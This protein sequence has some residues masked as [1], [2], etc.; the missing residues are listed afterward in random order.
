MCNPVR[1]PVQQRS[2]QAFAAQHFR[3]LR[4]GQIGG[5]QQAGAFIR[6][7]HHLEEQP[8][9]GLGE[10]DIAQLVEQ[11]QVQPLQ[12]LVQPL[13][14]AGSRAS[15]NCVTQPVVVVKR[16]RLPCVQAAKPKA[17]ARWVLPMPGLPTSNTF[18]RCCR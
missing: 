13:Q 7:A 15:S 4:E 6:P 12:W 18:S 14:R 10:R 8:G 16:T 2:G 1:E 9:P 3:P 11:Q 5:R 17:V